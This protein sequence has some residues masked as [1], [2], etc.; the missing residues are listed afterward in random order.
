MQRLL[1][2]LLAPARALPGLRVTER[3]QEVHRASFVR[4]D[5]KAHD[6][7]VSLGGERNVEPVYII[8]FGVSARVWERRVPRKRP[9][10]KQWYCNCLY[11]G[12]P[13]LPS[14]DLAGLGLVNERQ[15][16]VKDDIPRRPGRA[17]HE[18]LALQAPR[19]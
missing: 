8:D 9:C 14:C 19:P 1:R 16:K 10:N 18:P 13:L 6:I 15:F 7:P 17:V 12:P 3:L 11:D 5:L 2:R 4:C